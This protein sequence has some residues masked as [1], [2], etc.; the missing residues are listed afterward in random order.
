MLYIHYTY[1]MIFYIIIWTQWTAIRL[2]GEVLVHVTIEMGWW[3]LHN[4]YMNLQTN[5]NFASAQCS[6]NRKVVF[7]RFFAIHAW[8]R[9]T[10]SGVYS[11]GHPFSD[12]L[13][14][15]TND[16][17]RGF[18]TPHSMSSHWLTD[19]LLRKFSML[20]CCTNRSIWSLSMRLFRN[21]ATFWMVAGKFCKRK[22]MFDIV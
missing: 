20:K 3:M 7:S 6:G 18:I 22:K 21:D 5:D 17:S 4:K 12:A 13:P 15:R 10:I 1:I 9:T 14:L 16:C 2:S 11:F 8:T 19:V